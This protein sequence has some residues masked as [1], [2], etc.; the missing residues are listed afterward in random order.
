MLV[1]EKPGKTPANDAE[2][3]IR[4]V[5]Q[6]LIKESEAQEQPLKLE[7]GC[8]IKTIIHPSRKPVVE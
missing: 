8:H 6:M 5:F 2:L 4:E 7:K 3:F 1:A